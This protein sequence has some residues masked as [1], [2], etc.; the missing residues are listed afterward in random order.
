MSVAL[1]AVEAAHGAVT[2]NADGS[3]IYTPNAGFTGTDSFSYMASDGVLDSADTLVTMKVAAVPVGA[4]DQY[5]VNHDHTLSVALPSDVC[6]QTI[7]A[8]RVTRWPRCWI[9]GQPTAR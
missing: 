1:G 2:L 6:W 8:P 9:R 3:F 5:T 4:A 7:P